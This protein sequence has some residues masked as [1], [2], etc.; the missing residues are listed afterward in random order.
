MN[1]RKQDLLDRPDFLHSTTLALA[2]LLLLAGAEGPSGT[3]SYTHRALNGWITDLAS[4]PD[5]RVA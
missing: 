2:G 1:S 4:E 3:T 5:P